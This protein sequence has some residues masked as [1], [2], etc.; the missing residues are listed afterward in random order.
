[1]LGVGVCVRKMAA[2]NELSGV[3]VTTFSRV[4]DVG[5]REYPFTLGAEWQNVGVGGWSWLLR[6]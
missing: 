2:Q 4:R 3:V 1:M 5:L 6:S